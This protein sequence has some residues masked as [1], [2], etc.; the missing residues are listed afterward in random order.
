MV[1]LVV[2]V[3]G[4]LTEW[5]AMVELEREGPVVVVDVE[6]DAAWVDADTFTNVGVAAGGGDVRRALVTRLG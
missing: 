2:G 1:A 3:A 6:A 5:L 4:V